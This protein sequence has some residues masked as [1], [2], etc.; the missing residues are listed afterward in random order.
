MV[1]IDELAKLD[2]LDVSALGGRTLRMLPVWDGE[3]WAHW[4]TG[5]D[6]RLMPFRPVDA[7]HSLYLTKV[8]SADA[9]DVWIPLIDFVW[10][11]L[12][13]PDLVGFTH[14]LEDD[15]H[16]LATSA[17]KLEHFY[18]AR[19]TIDRGLIES[20]VR[21]EVE[22]IL[23]VARSVFDLLQ[24][25]IAGFWNRHVKLLD[26]RDDALKRQ[27]N[28]PPGFARVVFASEVPR[29]A[30]QIAGKYA[31]PATVAD[32][33]A[34]HAALFASLRTS[35]DHIIHGSSSTGTIFV[36]EKGF[37]VSPESKLYADF[38]WTDAHRFNESIVSLMPWI[39]RVVLQTIEACTEIVGALGSEI[40]CPNELAPGY[41]V[42][43]RD[44][45]N[46]ALL[47]LLEAATGKRV[48]WDDAERTQ[49]SHDQDQSEQ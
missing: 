45:A 41:R 44:P 35:R 31:L 7:A 30:E 19:D 1:N 46:P 2:H 42:L 37:A 13:Y 20:F 4:F 3:S 43:L 6:G 16:L 34:K 48:W 32:M 14:A 27:N 25:V 29:T 24:E 39:A 5:P 17:A 33:Y 22:Y 38:P 23:I 11:R 12:S 15:F 49:P 21:S 28:L 26:E 18:A 36:T 47:R 8:K 40:R 9:S 10:Q